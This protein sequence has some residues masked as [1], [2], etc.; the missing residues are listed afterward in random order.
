[1][2]VTELTKKISE[3]KFLQ[4]YQTIIEMAERGEKISFFSVSEKA[5][6]SRQF[7]YNHSELREL[8]REMRITTLK[9]RELQQ[10]ILRLR[11]RVHELEVLLQPNEEKGGN[12]M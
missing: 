10:E 5:E 2:K 11:L 6:V 7:L 4:A 9:K 12:P 3:E 8:I 1:M